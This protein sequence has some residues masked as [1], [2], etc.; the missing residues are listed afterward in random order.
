MS[1]GTC[2]TLHPHTDTTLLSLNPLIEPAPT[3]PALSS[4]TPAQLL[5]YIKKDKQGDSLIEKLC[6]RFAATEEPA[7]WHSIAFCLAQ[8]RACRG[9]WR[10]GSQPPGRSVGSALCIRHGGLFH[11]LSWAVLCGTLVLTSGH[12]LVP[13]PLQLPL[14]EK[15]LKKLSESFRFYKHALHDEEVRGGRSSSRCRLGQGTACGWV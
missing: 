3:A 12:N 5:A 4:P 10:R 14:S 2:I 8:V 7:Q 15:G 11:L 6:Q 13:T 9:R 1:S